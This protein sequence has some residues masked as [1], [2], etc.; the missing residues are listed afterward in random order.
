METLVPQITLMGSSLPPSIGSDEDEI[1]ITDEG[2]LLLL[3]L[4]PCA[5]VLCSVIT[6]LLI[7]DDVLSCKSLLLCLLTILSTSLVILSDL[8]REDPAFWLSD[9]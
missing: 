6:L 1:P 8:T 9:V 7:G 4:W 3:L 2:L 5:P